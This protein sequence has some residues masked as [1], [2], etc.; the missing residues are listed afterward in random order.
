MTVQSPKHPGRLRARSI[1]GEPHPRRARS[2]G[3]VLSILVIGMVTV[4]A[5]LLFLRSHVSGPRKHSTKSG[6][7]YSVQLPEQVTPTDKRGEYT[8]DITTNL[9]DGTAGYVGAQGPYD[10][11]GHCCYA[12]E[13]G[14]LTVPV[15]NESCVDS[16]EGTLSGSTFT[17]TVTVAPTYDQFRYG[18]PPNSPIQWQPQNVLD[19][20]GPNFENLSG[21]QVSNLDGVSELEVSADYA[22]PAQTC[23][24][25]LVPDPD[26]PSS[27]HRVPV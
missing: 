18:G 22:L 3:L 8:I 24:M 2:V 27:V 4:A 17:L 16:P 14:S 5:P 23:T 19:E 20:L 13:V 12:I 11:W 1:D 10:G 25:R 26:D 7:T 6:K 9:P 21:P 15:S